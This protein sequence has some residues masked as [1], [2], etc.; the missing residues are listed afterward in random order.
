[1]SQRAS[2]GSPATGPAR[3]ASL[4]EAAA[5]FA[6]ASTER[7]QLRIGTDLTTE[8]L[9]RVLEHEAGDLTCTVEAGIRL[10]TLR[11]TLAAHGDRR[12]FLDLHAD[13]C[14]VEK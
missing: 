8:R 14:R 6:A 2:D 11:A 1:M 7:R 3:P 9:D 10:S 4:E 12:R 13:R 5:L